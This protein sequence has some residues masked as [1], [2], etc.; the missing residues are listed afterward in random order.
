MGKDVSAAIK[1]YQKNKISV[2]SNASNVYAAMYSDLI[3][4]APIQSSKM[5]FFGEE[6]PFYE[7]VLQGYIPLVSPSL[8]LSNNSRDVLLKAAESGIGLSY[9]VIRNFDGKLRNEFDFFQNTCYDDIKDT[10]T[11]DYAQ[12]KDLYQLVGGQKIV[13][14][15]ILKKGIHKSVFSNGISVYTNFGDSEYVTTL[16]AL[17]PYSFVFG[18]EET[19]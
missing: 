6:I 19:P 12:I 17:K 14:H 3:L 7:M 4:D 18:K 8:N 11:Q 5:D 9:T 16:G 13:Q 1:E 10:V 15:M 2:L